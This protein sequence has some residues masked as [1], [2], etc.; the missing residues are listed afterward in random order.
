MAFGMHESDT[1]EMGQL[2]L[3]SQL[4]D[5]MYQRGKKHHLVRARVQD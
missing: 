2:Q 1:P 4:A 3:K 5:T